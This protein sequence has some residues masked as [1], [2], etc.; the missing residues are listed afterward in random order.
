[1]PVISL[2]TFFRVLMTNIYV[3]MVKLWQ[4]TSEIKHFLLW[5]IKSIPV[6]YFVVIENLC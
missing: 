2:L 5:K 3:F 6:I 4:L 1:M